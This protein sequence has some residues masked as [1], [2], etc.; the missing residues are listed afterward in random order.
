MEEN[1]GV[2]KHAGFN[3]RT[4]AITH[5]RADDHL[6]IAVERRMDEV[7]ATFYTHFEISYQGVINVHHHLDCDPS[8]KTPPLPRVGSVLRLP[9]EFSKLSWYG[10]GPHENYI[11]RKESA[12]IGIYHKTVDELYYP[13]IKPQ[14]NGYRTELR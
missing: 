2:W 6:K 10:R 3:A 5:T 11:D 7:F 4:V 8:R 13:Y 1:L 9:Y 12:L 14:E